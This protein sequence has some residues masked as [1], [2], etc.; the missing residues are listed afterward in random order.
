[1]SSNFVF[2]TRS[3]TNLRGVHRDLVRV[4]RLALQLSPID[5]AITE[6]VRSLERQQQ[7]VATGKSQTLNSRHLTGHALDVVAYLGNNVSWEWRCYQQIANAFKQAASELGISLEWGGDW[8]TLK[9]GP[10]FQLS[11]RNYPT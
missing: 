7:L 8:Q 4:A 11:H 6:G 3:E 2:S 10:H 9:D 5:F 1:M